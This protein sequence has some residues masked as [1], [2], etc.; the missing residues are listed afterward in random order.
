MKFSNCWT[1]TIFIKIP[2]K[3][4]SVM[5]RPKCVK[6][7]WLTLKLENLS[8]SM[9]TDDQ[10]WQLSLM[11]LFISQ[12]FHVLIYWQDKKMG[13]HDCCWFSNILCRCL[14]V[15]RTRLFAIR[16]LTLYWLNS[17]QDIIP[18]MQKTSFR[19]LLKTCVQVDVK[20]LLYLI[21]DFDNWC[22]HWVYLPCILPNVMQGAWGL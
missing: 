20:F 14:W 22:N 10:I 12:W 11:S 4:S 9:D 18:D 15:T 3:M 7:P 5:C 16:W 6:N 8:D 2:L 13:F 19:N 21:I 1:T 17:F